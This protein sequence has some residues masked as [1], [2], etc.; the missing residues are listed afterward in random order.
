MPMPPS[1]CVNWRHMSNERGSSSGAATMLAPVVVK[2]DIASK[3]ALIGL[4]SGSSPEKTYGSA[5]KP[6]ATIH[7]SDTTR[8]PSRMPTR[9][10]PRV[11]NSSAQ[12]TPAAIAPAARYG[13]KRSE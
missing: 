5:P 13:Q 1:H 4:L 9:S 8:K 10:L 11:T 2:P 12:P 3:Y 6:A 7:V